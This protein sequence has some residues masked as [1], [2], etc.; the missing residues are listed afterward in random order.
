[1]GLWQYSN[2]VLN[3]LLLSAFLFHPPTHLIIIDTT[4]T[5]Q[6]PTDVFTLL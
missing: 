3:K 4:T 1:M 2:S 5:I 6:S